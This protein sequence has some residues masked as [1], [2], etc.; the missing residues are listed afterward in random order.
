MVNTNGFRRR[1]T[2][3]ATHPLSLGVLCRRNAQILPL[4]IDIDHG[5]Y[6]NL[7]VDFEVIALRGVHWRTFHNSP[8]KRGADIKMKT[9]SRHLT[10]HTRPDTLELDIHPKQGNFLR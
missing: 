5:D 6:D 1:R 7:D 8:A 2:K 10:V 4:H 9:I 3:V